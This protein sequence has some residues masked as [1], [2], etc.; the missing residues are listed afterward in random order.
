MSYQVDIRNFKSFP[1]FKE[2]FLFF[3]PKNYQDENMFDNC[4]EW[5]GA[6]SRSG[7]GNTCYGSENYL[8][9]RMSYIIFNGPVRADQLIRHTCDN[10]KCVNPNHLII[11]NNSDNIIDM[12]KRNPRSN[13]LLNE[14]AVKVIKWNL[15][16]NSVKGIGKKLA[17]LYGVSP[18][19]IARIN[20]GKRWSWVNI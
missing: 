17:K 2:R 7:Y 13:I 20:T 14:E 8:A 18:S 10:P 12:V 16:F 19:V 15:K 6:I 3:F 5:Q 1:Q 9:H 11:G 4:W